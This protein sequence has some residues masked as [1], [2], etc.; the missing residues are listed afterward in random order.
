MLL[1]RNDFDSI[2]FFSQCKISFTALESVLGNGKISVS[3]KTDKLF[4][5]R[6][7]RGTEYVKD[8]TPRYVGIRR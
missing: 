7:I 1:E 2:A 8:G 3:D 5:R 4:N 6:Y